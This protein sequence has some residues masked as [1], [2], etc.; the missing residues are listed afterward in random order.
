MHYPP[1][2]QEAQA[3]FS[4]YKIEAQIGKGG[5]RTV[6]KVSDA[7]GEPYALKIYSP[8]HFFNPLLQ[9]NERFTREIEVMQAVNSPYVAKL[10]TWGVREGGECSYL[11]E[12]FIFGLPLND[13]LKQK[14][15]YS[16]GDCIVFLD[17]VLQGL[18]ALAGIKKLVIHRDIKPANIMVKE[19]GTPVI[20]DFSLVRVIGATI[21]PTD[22]ALGTIP[23]MPPET[24]YPHLGR[25]DETSDLFSLGIVAYEMLVGEHPFIPNGFVNAEDAKQY[26]VSE[27]IREPRL[28]NKEIPELLSRYV[29]KLLERNRHL[30]LRNAAHA[31]TRLIKI[32]ASL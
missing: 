28:V 11:V 14:G 20:T 25:A 29:V 32:Q 16:P 1:S 15:V 19:D 21:T 27:P 18:E 9:M 4:E 8:E 30:R 13:V 10:I 26:M 22:L 31:R 5:F 23:Y 7:Q 24:I 6:F 2:L 3:L 12:E 17:K